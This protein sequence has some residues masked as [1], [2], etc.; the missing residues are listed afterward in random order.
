MELRWR[1]EVIVLA[2]EGASG[3]LFSVTLCKQI[4][5]DMVNYFVFLC[6][7]KVDECVGSIF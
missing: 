7:E 3:L 5:S 1:R 6:L 4:T 2:T